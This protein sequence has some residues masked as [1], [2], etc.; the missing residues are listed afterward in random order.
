MSVL[1]PMKRFLTL[2]AVILSF[3]SFGN[4]KDTATLT[5]FDNQTPDLRWLTVNDTVMGGRSRGGYQVDDGI[6]VFTGRTNTNGGGFSSI[7][8]VPQ[9]LGLNESNEG[10]RMRIRGDG[11]VYTIRLETGTTRASYWAYFPTNEDEWLDIRIPFTEFWPNWRGTRLSGPDLNKSAIES[12]G[13]MIYDNLDGPFRL[14]VD[15]IKS[16]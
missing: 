4:T 16:Y 2:V 9:A 13:I 3:S 10:L 1:N 5:N 11:R 7:R 6:L 8:S 14:E 12:L 15:W